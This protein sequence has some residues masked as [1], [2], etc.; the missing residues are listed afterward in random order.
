MY[1][2]RPKLCLVCSK[3]AVEA[4]MQA[5]S[6]YNFLN[7]LESTL[8]VA[9]IILHTNFLFWP[10]KQNRMIKI[11]SNSM[12]SR[13][14]VTFIANIYIV[15]HFIWSF[16]SLLQE[17]YIILPCTI[18]A[19]K[20]FNIGW[21]THLHV[22]TNTTMMTRDCNFCLRLLFYVQKYTCLAFQ[23]GLNICRQCLTSITHLVY[24]VVEFKCWRFLCHP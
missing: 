11:Q 9:D 18:V 7:L 17:I 22:K 21:V 24:I 2:C 8:Y 10:Q 14:I 23:L 1:P 6:E 20:R 13:L 12:N 16:L 3:T 15:C 5:C 4:V 19:R